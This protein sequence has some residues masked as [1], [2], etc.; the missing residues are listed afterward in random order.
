MDINAL[1]E[2]YQELAKRKDFKP[3]GNLPAQQLVP[4]YRKH[5]KA[6]AEV[7]AKTD[8]WPMKER[9]EMAQRAGI[10]IENNELDN[11]YSIDQALEKIA[12]II[13]SITDKT[14]PDMLDEQEV[15]AGLKA[16]FIRTQGI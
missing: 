7:I 12:E 1:L 3:Y 14:D 16:F 9:V 11:E 15:R 8:K 5:V 10:S 2:Q 13:F 4:C 6:V